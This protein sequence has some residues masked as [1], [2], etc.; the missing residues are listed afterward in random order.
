MAKYLNEEMK[1]KI[2]ELKKVCIDPSTGEVRVVE[3]ARKLHLPYQS[4]HSYLYPER[5][6][7]LQRKALA[8]LKEVYQQLRQ[9]PNLDE[10]YKLL[11]Q[12]D[13]DRLKTML[14]ENARRKISAL[15]KY[16]PLRWLKYYNKDAYEKRLN[17][18]KNYYK[19][20]VVSSEEKKEENV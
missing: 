16:M 8:Q 19:S 4:V 3:I 9:D 1:K 17:Y 11:V 2:D 7:E 12:R 10:Y 15:K 6:R 13:Y 5:H 20:F 14:G 18:M